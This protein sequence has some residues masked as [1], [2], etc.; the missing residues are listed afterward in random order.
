MTDL[1][2]C[3]EVTNEMIKLDFNETLLTK[4]KNH[5]LFMDAYSQNTSMQ[6]SL[7]AMVFYKVIMYSNMNVPK[8]IRIA[9]NSSADNLGWLDDIKLVILPFIKANETA[10]S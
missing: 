9:L 4:I 5:P 2:L 1:D 6:K 10:F 8:E 7:I 3:K